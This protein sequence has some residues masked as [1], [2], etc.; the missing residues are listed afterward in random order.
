[1]DDSGV[2][3]AKGN[4]KQQMKNCYGDLEKILK[5]YGYTYNDVVAEN[6]YTTNMEDFIKV[7]GFL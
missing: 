2:I 5:H 7:S 3:V 4:M 1:M 6:I